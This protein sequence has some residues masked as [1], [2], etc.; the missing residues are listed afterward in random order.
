MAEFPIPA[1]VMNWIWCLVICSKP[2]TRDIVWSQSDGTKFD[3]KFKT[4]IYGPSK[5]CERIAF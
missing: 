2:S 3:L 4:F 1:N 5:K